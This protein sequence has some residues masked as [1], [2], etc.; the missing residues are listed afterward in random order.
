M[1]GGLLDVVVTQHATVLELF[2]SKNETLLVCMD[3]FL[4]LDLGLHVFNSIT[5][6]DR[7]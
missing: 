1:E 6:L 7:L 4:V 5:G 3:S 2:P